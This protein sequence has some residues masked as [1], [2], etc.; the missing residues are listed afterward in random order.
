MKIRFW[1]LAIDLVVYGPAVF[2]PLIVG[3]HSGCVDFQSSVLD[4]A[5]TKVVSTTGAVQGKGKSDRG[6][7]RETKQA[8]PLKG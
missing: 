7:L 5:G 1:A 8:S 3:L 6:T 2:A 4:C